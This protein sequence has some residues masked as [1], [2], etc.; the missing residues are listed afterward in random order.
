MAVESLMR[1]EA[2]RSVVKSDE[3]AI[4][5]LVIIGALPFALPDVWLINASDL[6]LDANLVINTLPLLALRSDF[7]P[8]TSFVTQDG[9]AWV[10][11]VETA[12]EAIH[13]RS[14]NSIFLGLFYG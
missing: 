11:G 13:F 6:V 2:R 3:L 8:L 4:R 12:T 5:C 10:F 14:E 9:Y 1:V 7:V